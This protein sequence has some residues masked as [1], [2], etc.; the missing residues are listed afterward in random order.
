MARSQTNVAQSLRPRQNDLG[1]KEKIFL[2]PRLNTP[3]RLWFRWLSATHDNQ[4]DGVCSDFVE[5]N[6][7]GSTSPV[8]GWVIPN[9]LDNSFFFYD[10]NGRAIGAF[11]IEHG[12]LKYRTRAGNMQNPR[13]LLEDDIGPENGAPLVNPHLA[14]IM[15][16]FNGQDADFIG[17]LMSTTSGASKLCN[18]TR[19]AQNTSL[20]V[21][22]GNPLA[23]TR[24]VLGL[25]SEGAVLPVSQADTS[26]NHPFADD[27]NN[28]RFEYLERQKTSSAALGDVQFPLRL[29]NLSN[30]DDGLVGF[31]I[32]K[33]RKCSLRYPLLANS[34]V[35][36]WKFKHQAT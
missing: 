7:H 12:E 5:M 35:I 36:W 4:V 2:P 27:V 8:F 31:F 15:W 1:N 29:G 19:F 26:N 25:E 23:L 30:I 34:S 6:S 9:H 28:N 13:D 11:G 3:S 33:P 17:T 16:Y 20:A 14:K 10:V 21:L 24:A 18:P 32:E 22:M